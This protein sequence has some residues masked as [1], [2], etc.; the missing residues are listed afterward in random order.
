MR[1]HKTLLICS[2]SHSTF[3]VH[4]T[5]LFCISVAVLPF[6]KDSCSVMSKSLWPYGLYPTRSL[7]SWDFPGNNTGVHCHFLLQGFPKMTKHN[8]PQ[9]LLF[10]SIFNIKM[11]TQKFI[12]IGFLKCML[13]WH[14]SQNSLV[15]LFWIKLKSTKHLQS[16]LPK[17]KKKTNFSAYP[18]FLWEVFTFL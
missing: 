12:N 1:L 2:V 9:M 8:R 16:H 11:A 6:L 5:D 4:C 7:C 17:K 15:K 18:V 14:L 10:S 3:C 13:I